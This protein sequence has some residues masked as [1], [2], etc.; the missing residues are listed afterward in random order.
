[1]MADRLTR[2]YYKN[3]QSDDEHLND[4]KDQR[5]YKGFEK[6]RNERQRQFSFRPTDIEDI[7]GILVGYGYD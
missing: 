3:P 5:S 2:G 4:S 7:Y 6:H 1:M